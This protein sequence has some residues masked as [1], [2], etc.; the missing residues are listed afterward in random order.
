VPALKEKRK[1]QLQYVSFNT[2]NPA[3]VHN[4]SCGSH[5]PN[6]DTIIQKSSKVK[7]LK[8]NLG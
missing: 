4:N 6:A 3:N 7:L 2:T 1:N 5:T 8:G